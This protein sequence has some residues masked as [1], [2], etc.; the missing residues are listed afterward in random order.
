MN[1]VGEAASNL[2]HIAFKGGH[3]NTDQTSYCNFTAQPFNHSQSH[4]HFSVLSVFSA[5]HA[6]HITSPQFTEWIEIILSHA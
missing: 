3:L 6:I 4:L 1:T 2:S 5:V